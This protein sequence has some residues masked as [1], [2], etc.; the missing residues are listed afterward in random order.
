MLPSTKLRWLLGLAAAVSLAGAADAS[1]ATT[2]TY[3]AST[4]TATLQRSGAGATELDIENLKPRWYDG[5]AAGGCFAP[6]GQQASTSNTQTILF[7]GSNGIAEDF[8]VSE[9]AG[10][11]IHS[12]AGSSQLPVYVFSGAE[13]TVDVVGT[14]GSDL[15]SITG[16]KGTGRQGGVS[17]GYA[18]APTV[19]LTS[20]PKLLRVHGLGGS[21]NINPS[22]AP[23][24][25][26]M[27]LELHGDEGPD[28]LTGG[29][30]AGDQLIGDEG[31]D[32]FHT[33]DGQPGDN[34]TGGSGSDTATIDR[35]DTAFGVETFHLGT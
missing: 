24:P 23:A 22:F 32:V 26:S 3:D 11:Y 13:D 10:A 34:I 31:D 20:D 4:Q 21:D 25:T 8:I 27:H 35:S 5:A 18:F 2:C 1:A 19:R 14:E 16:G 9:R 28:A 15:L 33:N 12:G 6:D 30:L 17:F 7:L 29:L